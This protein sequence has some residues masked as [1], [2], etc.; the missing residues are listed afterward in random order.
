MAASF[1]IPAAFGFYELIRGQL[2]IQGTFV[3]Q[4]GFGNFLV[5]IFGVF[6]C[7]AVLQSGIR[8]R[9]A[10]IIVAASGMLLI[11][12]F[13]RAGWVGAGVATLVVGALRKRVFLVLV[14]I[15]AII[16]IGMVPS[17][18]HRLENPF[19]GSFADR[20]GIWRST[21]PQWMNDTRDDASVVSTVVNRLVGTGPGTIQSIVLR[22]Y[23]IYNAEHN[24]YL[25]TLYENGVI[26][27][28]AYLSMYLAVL[29]SG[30][31]TWRRCADEKLASIPLSLIT[32][33][34]ATSVM[35]ITTNLFSLTQ[36]QLYLWTLAGLTAAIGQPLAHRQ[37]V[38]ALTG[39]ASLVPERR[40]ASVYGSDT[41][42]DLG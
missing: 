20:M 12:T 30:Y 19:E 24:D 38:P 16:V 40:G 22:A 17:V 36:N 41:V 23:G 6:L 29:I 35:S 8:R 34:L 31:R 10:W 21:A 7:Q 11:G 9:L 14:P 4:N 15:V 18:A 39:R 2:P 3:E 26:G 13:M 32:V 33:T 28:L 1:V 27:L 25:F 5:V 37:G 42:Q